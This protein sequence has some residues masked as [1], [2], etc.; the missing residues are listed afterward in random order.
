MR[1]RGFLGALLAAVSLPFGIRRAP[2]RDPGDGCCSGVAC[3]PGG[4]PSFSG[5]AYCENSGGQVHVSWSTQ[6]DVTV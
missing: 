2:V 1:R 6:T 3:D 4:G 5:I